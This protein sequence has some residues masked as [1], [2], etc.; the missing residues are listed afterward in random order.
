MP[1]RNRNALLLDLVMEGNYMK[2]KPG[3]RVVGNP[4]AI[5]LKFVEM[6]IDANLKFVSNQK[7][8][9]YFIREMN[10]YSCFESTGGDGDF[11]KLHSNFCQWHCY[12]TG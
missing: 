3:E 1:K 2:P 12:A 10:K 5:W 7:K 11:M 6:K 8:L 9:A 4:A